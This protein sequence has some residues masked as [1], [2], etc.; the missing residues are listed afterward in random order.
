LRNV[1]VQR[2][3]KLSRRC[4]VG[5]KAIDAPSGNAAMLSSMSAQAV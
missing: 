5:L 1:A 3:R 2:K 4:L